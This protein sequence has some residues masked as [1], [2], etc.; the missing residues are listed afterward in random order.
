MVCVTYNRFLKFKVSGKLSLEK[1]SF[2]IQPIHP[3]LAATLLWSS[4]DPEKAACRCFQRIMMDF[5]LVLVEIV[6]VYN[7]CNMDQQSA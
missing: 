3:P 2:E 7:C 1:L 4:P 6:M 5:L